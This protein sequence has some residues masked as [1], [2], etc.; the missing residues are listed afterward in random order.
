M[1]HLNLFHLTLIFQNSHLHQ[2][3]PSKRIHNAIDVESRLKRI[4]YNDNLCYVKNFNPNGDLKTHFDILKKD[5]IPVRTV[6][7]K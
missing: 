3:K 4:D 2:E 6:G 1:I 7:R 5:R